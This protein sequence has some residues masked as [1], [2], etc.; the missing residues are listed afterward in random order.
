M[1]TFR[2]A[3]VWVAVGCLL[4]E[5]SN[6]AQAAD[7]AKQFAAPPAHTRPW[8]YWF[9]LN[10]NI[11]T[12]GITADLEAMKRVGIGGVLIM[13][14]DQSI[15]KGPVPFMNSQ[16]R[17]LFQHVVTESQRLGLEVNM[18]NDAGWNGSG[19][20]WI[21]PEESM[22]KVV[23]T[24]TNI[25]GPK[26]FEGTLPQPKAVAGFYRDITVLAFPSPGPYRIPNIQAKACYQTN[27][28]MPALHGQVPQ[29][30]TI[31]RARIA[32]LTANMKQDGRF[33]WDVPPG[34][35]T[36]IRFGHTSTGVQNAP[37]PESGRGLECDKL[38]KKGIEANFA[39]MM[40]KLIAD[41]GPAAGKTLV[42]THIDSWENGAQNWTTRMR[43]EFRKRRG[44][45]LTP[46]LPVMTGR[47]V[48]SL[49]ISERFLWDLRQTISDLVVENY[50]DHL[51]TLAR[52]H[53]LKL[54][55]E[56]YG[57]PCDDAPYAGRAD[58]PMGEFWVGGGALT[59]CKE[60]A[61]AAHTY[62]KPIV[63][64]ESFT[65]TDQEKWLDYPA[66]IKAL[67]DRAFCTGINRFVFHRY[68]LQPWHDRRPGMT[69]GPWGVH[70]E[71][72]QTWWELTPAW[73]TYLA[74][75]QLMLRH[76]LFVAD[77]C[78]LQPEAAPQGFHGHDPKGY[79]FDNCSA[80]VV[81]TRM[82]VRDGRLVLPDGMSYR[83]LVLPD[84]RTMTPALLR[85]IKTLVQAGAT[86]LGP[87]PLKSPSLTDYPACD[88]QVKQLAD[89]LWAD[90]D[91]KS[92]KQHR[93][94]QG[95]VVWGTTPE[96]TLAQAKVPPDFTSRSR[97]GYIHRAAGD[98][99]V[100]FIANPQPHALKATCA[101]RV[102]GKRP[103]LWWPDTGRIEPAA[104]FAEKDALTSLPLSLDP[105][106]SVFVVF[107][108]AADK[109][110]DP[111]VTVARDGKPILSAAEPAP[112]I[113]VK[114]AVYGLLNDPARTR[115]VRAKV[116]QRVDSGEYA[117]KV[118]R[119]A[120]GDDPADGVVKTLV[121][122]YAIGGQSFTVTGQDTDTVHLTGDAPKIVVEKATYG[123]PRDAKRTRDV[124]AKLQHLVDTGEHTFQVA[125]MAQ[126]DDPAFG[127][128]KTLVVEYTIAGRRLTAKGTDPDEITLDLNPTLEQIVDLRC[129]ADGQPLVEAWQPGR[130]G[131]KTASGQTKRANVPAL[132]KP[133]EVG[134]PWQIHFPPNW[135][136]PQHITLEKLISWSDHG[137]TGVKYFSGTATYTTTFNVPPGLLGKDRRLYL[138]L[139]NVQVM[140]QVKSNGQDLGLLWKPPFRVNIT[141]AAKPGKNALEV[142]VTNLWVNR[143]IGDEQLPDDSQRNPNGTLKEWPQWLGEG[144][145]SPTGRFTFT[146]WRLWTK[147]QPPLESGLIGPVTLVSSEIRQPETTMEDQ[148][149]A[150]CP[151]KK[152]PLPGHV[153]DV[154]GHTAFVILPAQ[155]D[156]ARP[157]PWVWYAPTLPG[158]PEDRERWMFE[159]FLAAGMAVAGIDVGESYGS[160]KG[161]AAYSALYKKLIETHGLAAKAC[162]LARSR[163]GLMLYTWACE[164]PEAVACIAGIY[165]VCDLRSYPGLANASGAYGLS[166]AELTAQLNAHNP[167][168]RLAPLAKAGVP[169]FHIHGDV[170]T[171]VPLEKNSGEL[172]QR[173]RQLGGKVELL[174]PKGQGHNYWTGFFQCQALVDFVIANKA[175]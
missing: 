52:R 89:E 50:A 39:G 120:E 112:K 173:Y 172:A 161:R 147:D 59:T 149:Q 153:F 168:D 99:D 75:C 63:G 122:E 130:Y 102:S 78:Y 163:G 23:Y 158:L 33:I 56:A 67:G 175:K 53:K 18:N 135:G 150:R 3:W 157:T 76:G 143:L 35:W 113:V 37:A 17:E 136:A 44:Y 55:I 62:G 114:K 77:L 29:E 94:G 88:E 98:T 119:M 28:I 142:Q 129:G 12:E 4:V 80:E 69:M 43:D 81:L 118:S 68:A 10:G 41:V 57:G 92:V 108:D 155:Q 121:V 141:E 83:L 8:V 74:R 127:V 86:V 7:L 137:D 140:A 145:P 103:E 124:K 165:P 11:T 146:T 128:V 104:V 125:R 139:G 106:G 174:V 51:R 126:G 48:G 60:M 84:T 115:D 9:W 170:D 97:L 61:S 72:T 73:H 133:L 162:L 19:G 87:P 116:Q 16:W 36:V 40:N 144:K 46:F 79:D 6:P 64:A 100:Y 14:V 45:D 167:I 34:N 25:E 38:S 160:P 123:V 1:R 134:G 93:L 54:T 32:D 70:Y 101:F 27:F 109:P 110:V 47:V 5:V 13:E 154:N 90:C 66:T 148:P 85:K 111:I 49:D 132:P 166:E 95:R 20:P 151:E 171:A 152:L 31:D 15:P 131:L 2:K 159:K 82:T 42:A 138:D 65:A 24:E 30:M 107:R 26:R 22:Q 164:N 91:G 156:Q 96:A 58:E 169:I 117:F 21:K 71:R 105:S